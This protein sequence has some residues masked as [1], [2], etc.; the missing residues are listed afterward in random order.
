MNIFDW[1]GEP[2]RTTRGHLFAIYVAGMIIGL[3][4]CNLEQML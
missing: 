3:L 4:A 1:F 2:I